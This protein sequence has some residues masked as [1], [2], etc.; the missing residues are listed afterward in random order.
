MKDSRRHYGKF[1]LIKNFLFAVIVCGCFFSCT[2]SVK[3]FSILTILDQVDTYISQ[4]QTEA[5]VKLL[6]KTDNKK[7]SVDARLGIY[8]RYL[9]L[10]EKN[11]AEKLI[12]SALKTNPK[13]IK[14][15]ALYSSNLL[16]QKKYQEAF[17]ASKILSG[18]E[19]SSIYAEAFFRVK[20]NFN[21]SVF[22]EL[23]T[24]EYVDIFFDA[25]N[26]SKNNAWLRNCAC[27]KM[28]EANSAQAFKYLAKDFS[29]SEDA[30][31]WALVAY[32]SKHFVEASEC[33][34]KAKQMLD[35]ELQDSSINKNIIK[36]KY[37][38]ALIIR[39]LLADCYVNSFEEKLAEQ[40]RSDLFKYM[41]LAG[42]NAVEEK[43]ENTNIDDNY[44]EKK[45]DDVLSVV[46]LNSALYALSKSDYKVA[47]R[48][49]NFV[50]DKWPDFVPGLITYGNFAYDSNMRTLDDALTLE[51]RKL[52]I[53]SMDMKAFDEF[54]AI[55]VEDAIFRMKE[56]LNRFSNI[57][58]YVACLELEDK[59]SNYS[60]KEKLARIYQTLERN[61]IGT[62]LYPAEIVRYAINGLLRLEHIEEAEKLFNKYILVQ[63]Q[64]DK[65]NF[66][67]DEFFRNIHQIIPWQI[68]YAAWFAANAKKA[69]LSKRLY[70][71]VVY[72]EY[73]KEQNQVQEVSLRAT[74]IAIMNLAMI[75]SSTNV[76]SK[77]LELYG[78]AAS[79]AQSVLLKAESLY[80][81]GMLYLNNSDKENAIKSLRYAIYL[82]PAHS[83]ARILLSKL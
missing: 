24:Q 35:F 36:Q 33:L 66:F 7:L 21:S 81:I 83:K 82:N 51:L 39:A 72:N 26:G 55:P 18:T 31:F 19:Y 14:L 8:K 57:K 42:D 69:S 17:K 56:S 37:S 30:Y 29:D 3:S 64:F 75:Y 43:F 70:E 6:Q 54:P 49:L 58:L 15:T 22:E 53:S 41:V 78:F 65:N 44:F 38:L 61:S 12:K 79:N 13:S 47:Y 32:D 9:L 27:A 76:T 2:N 5:A 52:G 20:H 46:Y 45:E 34:T 11:L 28:L 60:E 74:T 50:V 73:L 68:E 40:E 67:Y 23:L 63:Y 80:R 71:F 77:A 16:K 48:L 10:G 62:N 25:Y 59:N 1:K 4:G